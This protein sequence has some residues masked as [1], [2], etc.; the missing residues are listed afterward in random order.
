MKAVVIELPPLRPTMAPYSCGIV[1]KIVKKYEPQCD[2][3]DLNLDFWNR[4]WVYYRNVLEQTIGNIK[5]QLTERRL[6]DAITILKQEQ[7]TASEV[8]KALNVLRKKS[9]I[10]EEMYDISIRLGQ[11]KLPNWVYQDPAAFCTQSSGN[12]FWEYLDEVIDQKQLGSYDLIFLSVMT[13][14]QYICACTLTYILKK[15]RGIKTKIAIGGAYVTRFPNI[16]DE[17]NMLQLFDYWMPGLAEITIPQVFGDTRQISLYY[18]Y[19]TD[20]GKLDF[21]EYYSMG[22]LFPIMTSRSCHYNQCSFCDN[23]YNYHNLKRITHPPEA[24]FELM[25]QA[26]KKYGVNKF[27]FIDD[28]LSDKFMIALAE[29]IVLRQA[30]F[31]WVA[32]ARFSKQLT[33]ECVVEKLAR[34]GCKELFLGMESYSQQELDRMNKGI[35][36]EWIKPTLKLLK[37]NKILV[38][39]SIMVGFPGQT[40]E[41]FSST[42]NFLVDNEQ[43]IDMVD[44]NI[45]YR[46][47]SFRGKD[48]ELN[49]MSEINERSERTEYYYNS[50]L[51]WVIDNKKMPSFFRRYA[52]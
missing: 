10:Y 24:V 9:S 42:Y 7:S 5:Y 28:C 44:I 52:W 26:S 50:L 29:T 2:L 32:N 36:T 45:F 8:G 33:K 34:G 4:L 46:T 21:D 47:P 20:F 25:E 15:K 35:R 40:D 18:E 22:K 14:E 51:R 31:R 43:Y 13:R 3:I 6:K 41:D 17:N 39:I 11:L 12:I 48:D 30:K 23:A 16:A 38:Y 27:C 1:T 37:A 49:S 19:E